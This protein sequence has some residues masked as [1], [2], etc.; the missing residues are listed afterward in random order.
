FLFTPGLPAAGGVVEADSVL[1]TELPAPGGLPEAEGAQP[2]R[3]GAWPASEPA[4]VDQF[5]LGFVPTL[6]GLNGPS[7]AAQARPGAEGAFDVIVGVGEPAAPAGRR[8]GGA[9]RAALPGEQVL[10]ALVE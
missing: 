1:T 6:P 3:P 10:P 7:P 9:D 4:T 5:A 8:Q 2:A